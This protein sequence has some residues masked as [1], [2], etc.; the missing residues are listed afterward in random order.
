MTSGGECEHEIWSICVP[1]NHCGTGYR[2]NDIEYGLVGSKGIWLLV[3]GARDNY[4]TSNDLNFTHMIL[5]HLSARSLVPII[6][7]CT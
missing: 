5:L 4:M 7:Y 1:N 3:H 2:T 6:T